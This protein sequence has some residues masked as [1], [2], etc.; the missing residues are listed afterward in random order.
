MA[1]SDTFLVQ[2][3]YECHV[4]NPRLMLV[5]VGPQRVTADVT[6]LSHGTFA[7]MYT[8]WS[9]DQP[10][11]P[12]FLRSVD[13]AADWMGRTFGGRKLSRLTVST[14]WRNHDVSHTYASVPE[15]LKAERGWD[16]ALRN[17]AALTATWKKQQRGVTGLDRRGPSG[18]TWR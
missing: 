13:A 15:F 14:G 8:D 6:S 2:E 10:S 17:L 1:R 9:V 7:I 3:Y 5:G 12:L 18:S 16:G 4:D 11:A